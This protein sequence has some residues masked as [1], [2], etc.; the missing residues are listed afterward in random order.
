MKTH[1]TVFLP[2]SP[3]KKSNGVCNGLNSP[4]EIIESMILKI[5]SKGAMQCS[6]GPI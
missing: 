4:Q 3:P 1:F 5:T 6:M 2:L